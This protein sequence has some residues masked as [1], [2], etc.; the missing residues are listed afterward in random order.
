LDWKVKRHI[1]SFYLKQ[2]QTFLQTPL[3]DLNPARLV[4]HFFEL[5]LCHLSDDHLIHQVLGG[6]AMSL[7]KW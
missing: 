7:E 1:V 6:P 3:I 5:F 4:D 2:H